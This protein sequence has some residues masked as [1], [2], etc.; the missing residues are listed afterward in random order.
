MPT[1]ILCVHC[2]QADLS[3][4][5]HKPIISSCIQTEVKTR[6]A[7]MK[8]PASGMHA[9]NMCTHCPCH[10]RQQISGEQPA[11]QSSPASLMQTSC[12]AQMCVHKLLLACIEPEPC[13]QQKPVQSPGK[14]C[15]LSTA[16]VKLPF[17]GDQHQDSSQQAACMHAT[18]A[19]T[20]LATVSQQTTGAANPH[21]ATANT[22]NRSQK[23]KATLTPTEHECRQ[24]A[25]VACGACHVCRSQLSSHKQAI[26][27]AWR[28]HP[29]PLCMCPAVHAHPT[30][31]ML[32]LELLSICAAL[33]MRC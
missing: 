11:A 13:P 33:L 4:A 22:M 29:K 18:C 17:T 14:P 24:S 6:S 26:R 25:P 19:F 7:T 3:A 21:R 10:S 20:A 8:H 32:P 28:H 9:R 16:A 31:S 5:E 27:H 1:R 15:P 23:R 30:T 12:V 2:A